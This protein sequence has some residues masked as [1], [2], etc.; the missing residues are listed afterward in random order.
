MDKKTHLQSDLKPCIK[1]G[2]VDWDATPISGHDCQLRA[3]VLCY[4]GADMVFHYPFDPWA[5][6]D[7]IEKQD[8]PAIKAANT[9]I[10]ARVLQV[11]LLLALRQSLNFR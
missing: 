10:V 4:D 3:P 6:A 11:R 2:P 1:S 7:A 5:M 8:K 9:L